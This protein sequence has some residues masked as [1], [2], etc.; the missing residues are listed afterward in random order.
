MTNESQSINN[1]VN[2]ENCIN[3]QL[4]HKEIEI[5]NT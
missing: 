4:D 2:T 5:G 1:T 3:I